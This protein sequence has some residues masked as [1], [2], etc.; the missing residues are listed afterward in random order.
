MCRKTCKTI[1]SETATRAVGAPVQLE[2]RAE[3]P[4]VQPLEAWDADLALAEIMSTSQRKAELAQQMLER[5]ATEQPT[6]WEPPALLA[7][8]ALREGKRNEAIDLYAKAAGLGATNPEMYFRYA[9]LLWNRSGGSDE[10]IRK[11]LLHA[12]E[13]K[14]DYTEARMRL[15]FALMDHG[16]Y[17]EAL[18]E[19]KQVKGIKMDDAFSYFH[20]AAYASY[21]TGDE[22]GAR[23]ALEKARGF[24]KEPADRMALDQLSQALDHSAES[25]SGES[26]SEGREVEPV[27][28]QTGEAETVIASKQLPRLDGTLNMLECNGTQARLA[29][30]S[31][32]KLVWFLIEDPRSVRMTH[33]GT[34]A[35][36]MDFTCGKQPPRPVTVEYESREDAGTKTMG[37]VRGI[38]F[39]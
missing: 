30:V 17:K 3:T 31:A 38:E 26:A 29:I 9:M 4:E 22:A 8:L 36:S 25:A 13:L 33:T 27:E 6:R 28:A 7:E 23:A 11:A 34:G 35:G 39:Q 16:D 2:K 24:A 14:P 1:S 10:A 32:G 12:V 21:R 19:L 15:G 18:A 20:A 5:L 37:V